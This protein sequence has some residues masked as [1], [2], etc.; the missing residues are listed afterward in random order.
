MTSI[1]KVNGAVRED[2]LGL[3][4]ADVW[5]GCRYGTKGVAGTVN[6][7]ELF[8]LTRFKPEAQFVLSFND[9]VTTH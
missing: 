8:A 3:L 7:E 5:V 4:P 2:F 1:I 6:A 9:H